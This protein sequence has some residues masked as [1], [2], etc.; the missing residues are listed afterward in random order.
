MA[1]GPNSGS[2][3]GTDN[4]MDT[5]ILFGIL[6]LAVAAVWYF[7]KEHIISAFLHVKYAQLWLMALVS[8]DEVV[9]GTKNFLDKREFS[10]VPATTAHQLAQILGSM[11][12]YLY[13]PVMAILTVAMFMRMHKRDNT[14]FPSKFSLEKLMQYQ[15]NI[16]TAPLPVLRDNP[17]DEKYLKRGSKWE[18]GNQPEEFAKYN[19]LVKGNRFK[20]TAAEKVFAAQLVRHLKGHK[21]KP[22]EEALLAAFLFQCGRERRKAQQLLRIPAKAYYQHGDVLSRGARRYIS[23]KSKA[24]IKEAHKEHGSH[25][26]EITRRHA[27]FETAIMSLLQFARQRAGVLATADFIWL[28]PT[29]RKLYYSLNTLGRSTHWC[30]VAGI[31]AHWDAEDAAQRPILD[32]QI[33]NA[34]VALQIKLI[35]LGIVDGNAEPIIKEGQSEDVLTSGTDTQSQ[36]G[37]VK[38]A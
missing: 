2:A 15:A 10:A 11:T 8:D 23:Q 20:L 17:A 18:P 7:W 16:F 29:D 14:M 34:V 31:W 22:H 9:Q 12:N 5:L 35:R 24:L 1:H 37:G 26:K 6:M 27:Y 21:W 13:I 28:R 30:E 19:S 38:H 36:S 4:D 32:P 33:N 3:R 25:W